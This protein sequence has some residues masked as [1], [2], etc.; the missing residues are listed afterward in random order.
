MPQV[1]ANPRAA[2]AGWPSLFSL[3]IAEDD[4]EVR[5]L[6]AQRRCASGSGAQFFECSAFQAVEVAFAR[7][8]LLKNVLRTSSCVT[9][10]RT[11][12]RRSVTTSFNACRM[13]ATVD[14]SNICF[15]STIGA[16]SI[17]GSVLG[18]FC[19]RLMIR[20]R[21][22]WGSSSQRDDPGADCVPRPPVSEPS[23]GW[24]L[25]AQSQPVEVLAL[26]NE[27]AAFSRD[28]S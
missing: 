12:K 14:A 24:A 25:G 17:V 28:L 15:T 13:T 18:L 4:T 26:G 21:Q 3:R 7:R 6:A 2:I 11:R 22:G 1:T 5:P 16:A 19:K 27:V 23:A 9:D 10:F 8:R 20:A